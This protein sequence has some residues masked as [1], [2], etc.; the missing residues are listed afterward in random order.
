VN[1]TTTPRPPAPAGQKRFNLVEHT[2][3]V[4]GEPDVVIAVKLQESRVRDAPGKI[5][6]VLGTHV[7]VTTPVQQQRRRLDALEPRADVAMQI[8]VQYRPEIP[9]TSGQALV[10]RPPA[11]LRGVTLTH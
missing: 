9:R 3:G 1:F 8:Q 2:V 7:A 10:A 6:C 11:P 4:A 5:P